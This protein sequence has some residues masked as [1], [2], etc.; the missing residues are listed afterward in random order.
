MKSLV[1]P[2][3]VNAGEPFSWSQ[4]C[5]TISDFSVN[6]SVPQYKWKRQCCF[7]ASCLFS[8]GAWVIWCVYR[9]IFLHPSV[10]RQLLLIGA[11]KCN[12]GHKRAGAHAERVYQKAEITTA[13]SW[14]ATLGWKLNS[15]KETLC[16]GHGQDV[17][18][19]SPPREGISSCSFPS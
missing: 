1:V 14:P 4:A 5:W 16:G 12:Q 17:C 15:P 10:L 18:F 13:G 7:F 9:D 6:Q 2:T 11:Q 8:K 3:S 19:P